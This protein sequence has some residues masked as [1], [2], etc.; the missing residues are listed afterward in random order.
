M[1][2]ADNNQYTATEHKIVA[3]HKQL[4][5]PADYSA[6]HHLKIQVECQQLTS[7]G[8]DI[9]AREQMMTPQAASAWLAMQAAAAEEG[10][11]LQ[12]V[13]AFRSIDYQAGIIQRKLSAGQNIKEILKVSAA[14]GFSE[15]HSGCALDITTPG[16]E[17][18]E[19]EFENSPAFQWLNRFADNFGFKMSYPRDNVHK[20]AYEPWHWCW[21]N[22]ESEFTDSS[23]R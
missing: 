4:G 15:H 14:P 3:L 19:E 16:C 11:E 12:A 7:I 20:V 13:S 17:P 6:R 1:T 10:V 23:P 22:R 18:L 2:T 9:F 5:I 8:E 21:S